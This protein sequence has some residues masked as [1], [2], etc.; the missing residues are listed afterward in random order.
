MLSIYPPNY[1]S[2]SGKSGSL[3]FKLKDL[4]DK[5]FFKS[6]LRQLPFT[7][8]AVLDVGGGTGEVLDMLK[9]ADKRINYTEIIDID[10]TAKN[11]AERKGHIYSHTTVE[12]YTSRRQFH[13]ILLLNIIEHVANPG[14]IIQ[15]CGTM[16][17]R[18]GII[19]IK[20]PN[21]D[22]LDARIF[23]K[24]YWGGLHCPRHWILF[25]E[26]SLRNMVRSTNLHLRKLTYTQ[27]APFWAWS[28][29]NL[30]RKKDIRQRKKP[31]IEHPM[32]GIL[33]VLFAGFDIL[34]SAVSKTSQMFILL[35]N[36]E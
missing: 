6:L 23:Q 12:N 17:E 28:V 13:V 18:G 36:S 11:H 31:L 5:R 1:Y 7:S 30:C 4:W 24:H 14:E 16:L 29:I 25:S 20:T 32:F 33:S 9:T 2:F 35:S 3:V 26:R 34:R 8:L 19:I 15:K 21:V 10:S 27:A 22:S